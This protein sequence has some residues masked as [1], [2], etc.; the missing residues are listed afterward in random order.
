MADE[1][2]RF[3]TFAGDGMSAFASISSLRPVAASDEHVLAQIFAESH[4]AGF[5]LLGLEPTALAGL[6]R[7]QFQARQA[8]YRAQPGAAEFLICRNGAPVGSCWLSESAELLRVLDIAVLAEH[9]RQGI[10]RSVLDELSARAA[11]TGK[12]VRLSVWGQNAPARALYAELGF[13]PDPEV[14]A[15]DDG[16]PGDLGNGYLELRLAPATTAELRAGAR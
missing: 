8:Q 10:A 7:M 4:C 16:E 2:P 14:R 6:I 5:D 1:I 15:N 12:P 13:L 3:T 11:A 9:R